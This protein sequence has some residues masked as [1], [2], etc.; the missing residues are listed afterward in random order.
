[1]RS[2]NF[3][4]SNLALNSLRALFLLKQNRKTSESKN[5]SWREIALFKG[6][7]PTLHFKKQ[8]HA[9]A[10]YHHYTLLAD[11]KHVQWTT[12]P[13]LPKQKPKHIFIV[14]KAL[15]K[16]VLCKLI[17]SRDNAVFIRNF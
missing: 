15:L 13:S 16:L 1:M 10:Q 5:H 14:Q 6:E 8:E 9:G 4:Q 11:S 3:N 7:I 12:V 2:Q 17:G